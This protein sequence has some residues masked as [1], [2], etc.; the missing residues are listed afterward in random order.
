MNKCTPVKMTHILDSRHNESSNNGAWS[1][2]LYGK[3]YGVSGLAG[4]LKHQNLQHDSGRL[5]FS[6]K[7][8]SEDDLR[9]NAVSVKT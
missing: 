1:Y 9:E 2:Y 4:Y 3:L 8:R 6:F 5:D 7:Y